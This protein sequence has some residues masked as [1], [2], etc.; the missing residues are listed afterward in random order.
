VNAT[1][2]GAPFLVA[3]AIKAAYDLAIYRLFR[4]QAIET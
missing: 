1:T 4:H 3:G 2:L